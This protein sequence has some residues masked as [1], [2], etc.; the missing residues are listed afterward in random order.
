MQTGGMSGLR[1]QCGGAAQQLSGC[2]GSSHLAGSVKSDVPV[3]ASC[4]AV[5]TCLIP[6]GVLRTPFAN[7][8]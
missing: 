1:M 2:S 4:I 6:G 8:V 3:L 7:C 5:D